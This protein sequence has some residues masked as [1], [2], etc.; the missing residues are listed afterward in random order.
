T[1]NLASDFDLINKRV[2]VTADELN[3]ARQAAQT[4]KRQQEEAAKVLAAKANS[5]DVESY[6]LEA[7]AKMTEIKE[8]ANTKLG[9][10][11]GEVTGIKQDLIST[12]ED[13]GRQLVDVKNVLNEG[14]ARN[15]GELAD[16]RKKPN[17]IISSS[18]FAKIRSAQCSAWATFS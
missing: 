10:V 13:F 9:T 5:S 15:S 18:I 16:L 6:R 7:A 14:I 3:Q 4:L 2:G 8:D 12:K 17:A 1:D 11:S